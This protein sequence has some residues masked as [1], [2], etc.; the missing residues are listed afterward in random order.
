MTAARKLLDIKRKRKK[1]RDVKKGEILLITIGQK[2]AR[3][4][5]FLSQRFLAKLNES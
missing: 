2:K 4:F 3:N 1:K 5:R